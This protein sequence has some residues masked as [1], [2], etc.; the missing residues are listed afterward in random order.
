MCTE[1]IK[2]IIN[3]KGYTNVGDETRLIYSRKELFTLKTPDSVLSCSGYVRNRTVV[4][5]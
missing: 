1:E 5:F 2:Y 4:A 3:F